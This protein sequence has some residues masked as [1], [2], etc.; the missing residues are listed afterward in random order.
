MT[1]PLQPLR[2]GSGRG[3]L[4]VGLVF[5][6][7]VGALAWHPWSHPGRDRADASVAMASRSGAVGSSPEPS[8]SP[9]VSAPDPDA[10]PFRGPIIG[11]GPDRISARWSIVAFIRAD[12]V[13]RDPLTMSQQQVAVFVGTHPLPS[14]PQAICDQAGTVLRPG[15]VSLRSGEVSFLGIAFPTDRGV[16]VA[17]VDRLGQTLDVLPVELGPTVG[18]RMFGLAGG[19]TWP[20]GVYRFRVVSRFGLPG[21]LYACIRP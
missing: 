13:S 2:R 5:L 6:L 1:T 8:A 9:S 19:G 11:P 4:L 10:D 20:D 18:A 21:D 16:E 7:L 15:A 12:P 3:S 17:S 14:D